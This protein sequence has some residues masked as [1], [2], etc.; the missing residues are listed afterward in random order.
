MVRKEQEEIALPKEE[1][2]EQANLLEEV[3]LSDDPKEL[4]TVLISKELTRNI[5]T[6][7]V[8]IL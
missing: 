4:R 8:D 3:N 5:R 2:R 1:P 7:V 6:A